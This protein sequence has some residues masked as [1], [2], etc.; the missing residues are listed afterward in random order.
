MNR[1]KTRILGLTLAALSLQ[2][3]VTFAPDPP[4]RMAQIKAA[5]EAGDPIAQDQLG[6]AYQTQID[7]K[8]AETWYRKAASQGVAHAQCSMGQ[9]LMSRATT[10]YGKPDVMTNTA[11]E[12]IQWYL[13]AANQGYKRAQVD[14]GRQY[15]QGRFIKQDYVEAYKWYALAADSADPFDPVPLEGKWARD[16][17]ILKMSQTQIAEARNRVAAFTPHHAT[18]DE[19]PEPAWVKQIQLKGI[20]GSSSRRLALINGATFEAGE[21]R[22]VKVSGKSV[23][24]QCVEIKESSAVVSIEGIEGTR[25]LRMSQ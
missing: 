19:L 12:A 8:N 6:K 10:A 2:A 5:A 21:Q 17:V 1:F 7:S 22:S 4:P 25:E 20:S 13:K 3:V 9:I 15:E 24:V 11:D 14:L 18:K 23:K 16:A